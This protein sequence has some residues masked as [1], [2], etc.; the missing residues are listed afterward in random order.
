M[1]LPAAWASPADVHFTTSQRTIC[2]RYITKGGHQ[3]ELHQCWIHRIRLGLSQFLPLYFFRK[4]E[5][6]TARAALPSAH[7]IWSLHPV[8]EATQAARR[9]SIQFHRIP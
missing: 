9:E 6:P 8:I 3:Q 2:I 7:S 5:P 4:Y 1:S